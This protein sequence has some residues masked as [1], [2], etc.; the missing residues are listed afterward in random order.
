M[1]E[2]VFLVMESAVDFEQALG[3]RVESGLPPSGVLDWGLPAALFT[4]RKE[5]H[6]AIT[7][8]EHY[9]LAFG[10]HQM[11]EKCNCVIKPARFAK[12]GLYVA[13]VEQKQ[14]GND[15]T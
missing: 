3:L 12:A 14:G 15:E 6:E 2:S 9:R 7:R 4:S 11:P 13:H 5:A 1:A 10:N 8:T